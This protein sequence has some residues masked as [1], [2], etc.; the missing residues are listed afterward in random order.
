MGALREFTADR[1]RGE[2]RH[3]ATDITAT[4]AGLGWSSAYASLQREQPFEANLSRI[5]DCLLILHRG[6]PVSV[7][8]RIDGDR[9]ISQQRRRGQVSFIPGS[10]GGHVNL[11]AP[12]D[13]LH[14]YLSS[15]LFGGSAVELAPLLG[16]E[17]PILENLAA[18]IGAAVI[19][20]LPCSALYVDPVAQAVAIRILDLAGKGVKPQRAERLSGGQ[21]I[22]I[23]DFVEAHLEED[24]RVA[25]LAE[26]C[27]VGAKRLKRSFQV[28]MGT[29]PYQYVLARRIGRASEL[30]T[31]KRLSLPEIALRSGFCHQ[32]HLT[33]V[34]RLVTGQSPGRYRSGLE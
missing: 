18:A 1:I 9:A 4:S 20:R 5:D 30:L 12:H 7:T 19:E 13:T 34:F 2:L 32:E 16:I 6:G 29:T 27:G 23:R 33:R 8:F 28:S 10:C 25:D 26:A 11:R 31:D 24:I 3:D 17:D 15:E 14:V 22:R 21:L